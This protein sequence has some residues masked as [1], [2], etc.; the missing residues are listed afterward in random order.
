[1][2]QSDPAGQVSF[3]EGLKLTMEWYKQ[4]CDRPEMRRTREIARPDVSHQVSTN[5]WEVGTDSALAAHPTSTECVLGSSDPL[6]K[7]PAE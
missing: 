7:R 5:W 1:M 6:L 4:A 3:E 2:R